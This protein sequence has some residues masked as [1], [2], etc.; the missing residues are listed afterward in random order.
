MNFVS[1]RLSRVFW[2]VWRWETKYGDGRAPERG[3]S[4][5]RSAGRWSARTHL[6]HARA[7][8]PRAS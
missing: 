7:K 4:L 3:I 5:G 8:L 1:Y 2:F 6:R